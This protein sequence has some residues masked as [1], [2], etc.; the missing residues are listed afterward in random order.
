MSREDDIRFIKEAMPIIRVINR[1]V[2][3]QN[4]TKNGGS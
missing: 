2:E 3:A 1:A 4:K